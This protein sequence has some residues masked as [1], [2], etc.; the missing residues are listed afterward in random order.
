MGLAAEWGDAGHR[1]HRLGYVPIIELVLS[2][3][4]HLHTYFTTE[5][6]QSESTCWPTV[7]LKLYVGRMH[8]S[9][10]TLPP[11]STLSMTRAV[12]VTGIEHALSSLVCQENVSVLKT[13][14]VSQHGGCY[15]CPTAGWG[16]GAGAGCRLWGAVQCVG[17]RC[18]AWC[19]A[20]DVGWVWVWGMRSRGGV[21]IWVQ[22]WGTGCRVQGEAGISGRGTACPLLRS[23]APQGSLFFL[24]LVTAKAIQ[25]L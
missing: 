5:S 11:A 1:H 25:N 3:S 2:L 22:M 14:T 7:Y 20:W 10:T 23:P 18:R 16:V 24:E 17:C 21:Q 12:I 6:D 8:D 13:L 4:N 19:G 9:S 15:C